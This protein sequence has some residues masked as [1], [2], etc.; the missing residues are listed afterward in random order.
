MRK[1]HTARSK[2]AKGRA[3][4]QW[5]A[6]ELRRTGAD[7]N[8]RAMPLSGAIAH[9]KS[10]IYTKLP[11]SFECKSQETTKVWTWYEQARTQTGLNE[12]PVVV[13]KRNYSPPLA[14]LSAADF[15]N[16]VAEIVDLYRR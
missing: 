4:E 9:F 13:F 15:I 2:K 1:A 16:M 7:P 14:L 5:L 11:Y 10:D 3:L 8:A 6:A 12:T